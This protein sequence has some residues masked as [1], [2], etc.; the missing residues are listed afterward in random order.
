[1]RSLNDW[2]KICL[3]SLICRDNLQPIMLKETDCSA[4][5]TQQPISG[6][7]RNDT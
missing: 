7:V 5:I 3:F 2:R 4:L 1:M 6:I